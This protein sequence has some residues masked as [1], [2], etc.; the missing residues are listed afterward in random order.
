MLYEM[1]R[2]INK[3]KFFRRIVLTYDIACQ[4]LI[5]LRKRF[6]EEFDDLAAILDMVVLLVP[7]MHLDGHVSDCKYRYSLNY[8][9][10]CA[11]TDGEGI[12]RSWAEQ[13]PC[14]LSTREM[15]HGHRHDVLTDFI[16]WWNLS[17]NQNMRKV[18][19]VGLIN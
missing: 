7:K 16:D 18:I 12:E 13:K 1:R 19:S 10:G 17:R 4:Y 15:N 14:G 11:R 5:N 6:G 8:T 9:E 3:A 2:W